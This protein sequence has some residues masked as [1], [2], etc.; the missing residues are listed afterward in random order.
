MAQEVLKTQ[1]KL[2]VS[3]IVTI[4]GMNKQMEDYAFSAF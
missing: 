3:A 2:L 1:M 4:W